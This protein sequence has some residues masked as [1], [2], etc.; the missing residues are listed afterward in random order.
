MNMSTRA[1]GLPLLAA[2]TLFV[3][4]PPAEAQTR[5]TTL[6]AAEA[7]LGSGC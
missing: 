6:H 4:T 5:R 3:L 1:I 2:L 7:G